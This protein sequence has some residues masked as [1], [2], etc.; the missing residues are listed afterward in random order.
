MT[1]EQHMAVGI[2]FEVGEDDDRPMLLGDFPRANP[3]NFTAK[4]C[5]MR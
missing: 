5:A 1:T 4:N 3:P 2:S